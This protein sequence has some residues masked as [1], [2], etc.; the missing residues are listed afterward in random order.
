MGVPGLKTDD[1]SCW[2]RGD[3]IERLSEPIEKRKRSI[4]LVYGDSGIG[5]TTLLRE[6]HK[7]LAGEGIFRGFYECQ[8]GAGA[9]P[10]LRCLNS[11][12]RDQVYTVE[13]WPQLVG[14]GIAKVKDRLRDPDKLQQL[15]AGALAAAGEAPIIGKFAK[16]VSKSF[17][18][19]AD[20]AGPGIQVSKEL[21][22]RLPPEVFGDVVDILL[23]SF[24]DHR[25]VFLIDNLSADAESQ[26]NVS[27]TTRATDALLSYIET[28]FRSTDHLHFVVS[29]KHIAK[30]GRASKNCRRHSSNTAARFTNWGCFQTTELPSGCHMTLSGIERRTRMRNRVLCTLPAASRKW[31][32]NGKTGK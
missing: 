14:H 18:A 25:L 22:T 21:I 16:V 4:T 20:F 27:G 26:S 15:S 7:R 12:L 29:W 9:D 32:L 3:E 30:T 19:V 11:L 23:A 17:G 28:D 6:L 24:P 5:K 8:R 2:G 1:V 10:L 31:L 13:S